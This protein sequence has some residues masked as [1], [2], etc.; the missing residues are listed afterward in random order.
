MIMASPKKNPE[1]EVLKNEIE[2][3]DSLIEELTREKASLLK[4]ISHDIGKWNVRGSRTK[5]GAKKH[6]L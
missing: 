4:I 3:K 1:I 2:K 5:I 6:G